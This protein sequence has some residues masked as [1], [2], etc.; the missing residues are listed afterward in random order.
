MIELEGKQMHLVQT[1]DFETVKSKYIEVIENTPDM[2]KYSR[3]IYGKH[4]TDEL[5]KAYIDRREMYVLTDGEE[6]AGMA[7][8]A[9]CQEDDYLNISWEKDLP[10]DEVATVHL[11]AVCPDYRGKSLGLRILDEATE[12]AVQKGK[13]ALRLDALKSNLP[14]QKMY[15]KAGFIY[16]GEQRLYAENTGM[17]EFL[18]YEK[19]LAEI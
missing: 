9:L 15:E 2:E 1:D 18:Y 3:W 7:A 8:V 19:K 13:K 5:L 6:I 16:R 17:T 11:L 14:A 4:P 12:I 10:K